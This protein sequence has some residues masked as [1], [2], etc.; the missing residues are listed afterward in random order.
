MAAASIGQDTLTFSPLG[1]G[2]RSPPPSTTGSVLA[3]RLVA[4]A[5]DD[6]IGPKPLPARWCSRACGPMMSH[7]LQSGTAAGTGL[8]GADVRQDRHGAVSGR[9]DS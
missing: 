4:G 2:E 5:A 6:R 7:V 3:P 9:T 8:P 1:H